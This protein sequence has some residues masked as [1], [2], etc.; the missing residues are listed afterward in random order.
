MGDAYLDGSASESSFPRPDDGDHDRGD[1]D[2]DRG[3]KLNGSRLRRK[4]LAEGESSSE[5]RATISL[6]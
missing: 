3:W 1:D 6:V 2:G 4:P 5:R